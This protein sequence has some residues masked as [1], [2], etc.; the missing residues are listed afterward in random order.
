MVRLGRLDASDTYI[1]IIEKKS[2]EVFHY[3]FR[4]LARIPEIRG[5]T[6]WN[7]VGAPTEI[8]SHDQNFISRPAIEL[9]L[10]P[11]RQTVQPRDCLITEI[12]PLHEGN[13]T[14]PQ[15]PINCTNTCRG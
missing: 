13:Q 7:W 9:S 14:V 8:Q 11:D 2:L 4:E 6:W 12:P 5:G 15:Q 10:N 3:S 1:N